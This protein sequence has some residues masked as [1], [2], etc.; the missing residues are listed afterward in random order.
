[1]SPSRVTTLVMNS[2]HLYQRLVDGS[3]ITVGRLE[4]AVR[5]FSAHWPE[6]APWP[7]GIARPAPVV[8]ED[9]A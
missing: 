6:D 8:P 4:A 5:W 7:E 3:D 1:M 2:G 9:A